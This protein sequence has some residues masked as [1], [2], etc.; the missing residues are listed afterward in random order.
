MIEWVPVSLPFE[1]WEG[2]QQPVFRKSSRRFRPDEILK[3]APASESGRQAFFGAQLER[4]SNQSVAVKYLSTS[5]LMAAFVG[6]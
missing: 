6:D 4:I 5:S 2:G 3:D 1:D